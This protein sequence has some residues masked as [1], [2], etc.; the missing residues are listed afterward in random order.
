M[1][2]WSLAAAG[3]DC[4]AVGAATMGVPTAYTVVVEVGPLV[5]LLRAWTVT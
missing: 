4:E 1:V 5:E 3:F 2:A